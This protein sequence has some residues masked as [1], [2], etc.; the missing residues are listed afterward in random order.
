[1]KKYEQHELGA[2]IPHMTEED[3][4]RLRESIE[5]EGYIRSVGVITTYEGKILDG[6]HRYQICADLGIE[7]IFEEHKGDHTSARSLSLRA[8]LNRRHLNSTQKAMVV[9]SLI[10]TNGKG[11][12][13]SSKDENGSPEPFFSVKDAAKIGGTPL[14]TMKRVHQI[15]QAKDEHSGPKADP[16]LLEAMRQGT[17]EAV[18]ARS[19]LYLPKE[20]QARCAVIADKN[21]RR[22]K[23]SEEKKKL[24]PKPGVALKQSKEDP[25]IKAK[26]AA[27][28]VAKKIIES[29]YAALKGEEDR[30]V[31][32]SVK[33]QLLKLVEKVI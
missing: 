12:P 6:W 15:T 21:E 25:R 30:D 18:E 9:V 24:K 31:L 1:M 23:L 10:T 2:L 16:Q 29:G 28:K 5:T 20:I 3:F 22:A 26:L 32:L 7:P 27:Q 17:I 4:G 19:L 14:E 8:N 13:K 11:R 33:G